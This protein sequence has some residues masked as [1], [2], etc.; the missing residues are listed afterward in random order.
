MKTF[1]Q[2]L[3]TL[4][5]TIDRNR[6]TAVQSAV[7]GG[8]KGAQAPRGRGYDFK[9]CS[10]HSEQTLGRPLVTPEAEALPGPARDQAPSG[11]HSREGW[12]PGLVPVCLVRP[13]HPAGLLKPQGHTSCVPVSGLEGQPGAFRA[14]LSPSLSHTLWYVHP[15]LRR[16]SAG[17]G[18]GRR[19]HRREADDG[20]GQG[21]PHPHPRPGTKLTRA[22]RLSLDPPQTPRM[23]QGHAM[24]K[25]WRH[26]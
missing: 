18:W 24:G 16:V 3:P 23:K 7:R 4:P 5:P 25:R 2:C 17:G 19:P 13:Q 20:G 10:R 12:F 1:I 8:G 14:A 11:E 9:A 26:S 22:S 15:W 6:Q 21:V